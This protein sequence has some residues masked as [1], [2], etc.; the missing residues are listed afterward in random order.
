MSPSPVARRRPS[1]C[2]ERRTRTI[3]RSVMRM[4]ASPATPSACPSST[5]SRRIDSTDPRVERS[6]SGSS[7]R[8]SV[9]R[10]AEAPWRASETTWKATQS[11]GW[12][13]AAEGPFRSIVP[14]GGNNR[15]D[16]PETSRTV[17]PWR[18]RRTSTIAAASATRTHVPMKKVSRPNSPI[19]LNHLADCA[20]VVTTSLATA[21]S[22]AHVDIDVVS[23]VRLAQG[24]FG[25]HQCWIE[26]WLNWGNVLSKGKAL[27]YC[28]EMV[29]WVHQSYED[30]NSRLALHPR[31]ILL[32]CLHI[33]S[34]TNVLHTPGA[35]PR[36]SRADTRSHDDPY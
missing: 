15:P 9:T 14:C 16:D 10:S 34:E 8:C 30:Q 27:T 26:L 28:A 19:R 35:C 13:D 23:S 33:G 5:S 32:C 12:S 1:G 3:S 11:P 22:T 29:V 2:C 7:G 21:P 24:S 31:Q 18:C 36:H 4:T 25:L 6:S 17:L 20:S